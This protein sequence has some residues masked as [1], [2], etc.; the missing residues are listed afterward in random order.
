MNKGAE[1][2]GTSAPSANNSGTATGNYNYCYISIKNKSTVKKRQ[3]E[4]PSMK[5]VLLKQ[6]TMLL[7]GSV[8]AT[9][10]GTWVEDDI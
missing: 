6:R 7:A 9:M 10:D 3:Y 2:P 8:Q 5:V 1:V 4:Q